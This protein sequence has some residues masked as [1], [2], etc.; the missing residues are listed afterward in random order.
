[1]HSSPVQSNLNYPPLQVE[2]LIPPQSSFCETDMIQCCRFIDDI[3]L[4]AGLFGVT[5]D[6][7]ANIQQNYRRKEICALRLIEKWMQKNPEKNKDDL[8]ELLL[9]ANQRRAA[10][11]LVVQYIV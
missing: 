4:L 2:P 9:A 3:E 10:R 5:D 7:L 6:E 11:R 1:M 8:Y